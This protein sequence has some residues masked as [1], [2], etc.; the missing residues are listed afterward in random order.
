MF[1]DIWNL[2]TDPV[3]I[4]KGFE[5]VDCSSFVYAR[6]IRKKQ[7]DKHKID[8]DGVLSFNPRHFN[9]K[10]GKEFNFKVFDYSVLA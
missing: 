5:Y 1:L 2:Y 8:F 4:K 7:Y 3:N 10:V 9:D 6:D